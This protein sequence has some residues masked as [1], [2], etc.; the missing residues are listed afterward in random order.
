MRPLIAFSP[1]CLPLIALGLA[2]RTISDM[3]QSRIQKWRITEKEQVS[4]T[5]PCGSEKEKGR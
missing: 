1:Y 4:L 3:P 5:L 2:E